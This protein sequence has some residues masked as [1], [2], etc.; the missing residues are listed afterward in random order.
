MN[1]QHCVNSQSS[2]KDGIEYAINAFAEKAPSASLYLDAA[3]GGWLGWDN[4]MLEFVDI[5]KALPYQKLRG[6]ATN[7]ANYQSLG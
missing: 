1:N 4:N 5:V 7:V 3:H 6:F 2:Y